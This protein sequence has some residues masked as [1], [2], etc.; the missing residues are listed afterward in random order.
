MQPKKTK[1]YDKTE[2]RG[3][4]TVRIPIKHLQYL[5]KLGYK[6]SLEESRTVGLNLLVLRALDKVYPLPGAQMEMNFEG[7]KE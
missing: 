1:G 6:M 2:V 3:N 4:L 7:E 5:R